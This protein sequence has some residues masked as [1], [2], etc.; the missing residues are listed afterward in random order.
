VVRKIITIDEDKCTGCGLCAGAC[1][2]GAIV[3]KAG[4]AKLLRDDYC[5]GLGDCLP[6]CSTGAITFEER[7]ALPYDEAAVQARVTKKET[8]SLPCG[9]P[10]S[11]ARALRRIDTAFP[12]SISAA[13]EKAVSRLAQWPVQIR[14]VPV[15][16][17]YFKGAHL[18]ISADCAAYAHGDF[19]NAFMKNKVT[20]IGCPKLDTDDYAEKLAAVL[21]HND[22]ASVA[23]VRMEVPCCRGLEHAVARALTNCGRMIPRIVTTIGTDGSILTDGSTAEVWNASALRPIAA[24][25]GSAGSGE[26]VPR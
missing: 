8:T 7:E 18:L 14:L 25:T 2:E 17:S 13:V 21:R 24:D 3:M 22:I 15:T 16:A 1:H 6:V 20:L 10:G 26:S 12:E 23:V 4:K 11:H 19:H 9:C 5:D